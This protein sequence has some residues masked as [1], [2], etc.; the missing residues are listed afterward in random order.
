MVAEVEK[1][2]G[3]LIVMALVLSVP[4]VTLPY[5]ARALPVLT[6]TGALAVIADVKVLAAATARV[7]ELLVPIMTFPKALRGFPG[8]MLTAALAVTGAVDAKV[9]AA[10]MAKV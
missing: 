1:V 9:V 8:E 10:L 3:E 2:V 7:L 5:A 4:S 6:V